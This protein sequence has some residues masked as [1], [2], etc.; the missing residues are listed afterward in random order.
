MKQT[1]ADTLSTR[2]T[3]TKEIVATATCTAMSVAIPPMPASKSIVWQKSIV[4]SSSRQTI[5]AV[6]V[7]LAIAVFLCRAWA[8]TP[9][10]EA[11][12]TS[13]STNAAEL[14]KATARQQSIESFTLR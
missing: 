4:P 10:H 8:S 14:G 6:L 12:P 9:R 13:A 7:N 1:K 2:I 11:G 5:T 3:L